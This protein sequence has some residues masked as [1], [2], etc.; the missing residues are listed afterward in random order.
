MTLPSEPLIISSGKRELLIDPPVMNAAGFLGFP[1]RTPTPQE[2]I[3]W[4]GAHISPPTSLQARSPAADAGSRRF[5]GGFLL[6]SGHPNPGLE[7][8]LR[9][10]VRRW[11]DRDP[12]VLVHLLGGHDQNTEQAL[13][14]LEQDDRIAG[15]EIGLEDPAPT[16]VEQAASL[17]AASEL[18]AIVRLPLD[19][20]TDAFRIAESAGAAALSFGPPRGRLPADS[21]TT[22]GRMYGP[23]L[24]PL[25]LEKAGS[26]AGSLAVPVIASGGLYTEENLWAFLE[27]GAAGVQLD[28]LLWTR[29]KELVP[30]ARKLSGHP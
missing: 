9:R 12:P 25:A 17:A 5:P 15:V 21:G 16:A 4:L 19:A 10:D 26:L 24:F 18:P 2:A 20:D 3:S 11:A 7:Q 6:H 8:V 14:L 27:A 30:A 23:A 28:G 13:L 22:N 29:P 1:D